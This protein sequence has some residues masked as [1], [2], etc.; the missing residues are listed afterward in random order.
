MY[1]WPDGDCTNESLL[2]K[3]TETRRV[4]TRTLL[5]ACEWLGRES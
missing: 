2:R 3:M 5:Q 4:S 1:Q